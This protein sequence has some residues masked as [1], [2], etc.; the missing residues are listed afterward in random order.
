[1]VEG[2]RR[3]WGEDEGKKVERRRSKM[4]VEGRRRRWRGYEGKKVERRRREDGGRGE[5]KKV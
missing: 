5:E 2:R 4:V 1:M 3:R